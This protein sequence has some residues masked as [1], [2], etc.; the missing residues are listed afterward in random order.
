MNSKMKVPGVSID[1]EAWW[2][3]SFEAGNTLESI[4]EAGF[5][6]IDL[7]QTTGEGFLKFNKMRV[8][9]RCPTDYQKFI[10]KRNDPVADDTDPEEWFVECDDG[11]A[12]HTVATDLRNACSTG[13]PFCQS[14]QSQ[15][16][17]TKIRLGNEDRWISQSSPEFEYWRSGDF[18][19]ESMMDDPL[20][21]KLSFI[22][23][24]R[25]YSDVNEYKLTVRSRTPIWWQ[26][27]TYGPEN[28]TRLQSF[29][30][31]LARDE[32]VV[33][34]HVFSE[35]MPDGQLMSLIKP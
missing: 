18:R 6:L 32:R 5:S 3:I 16:V 35:T 8:L 13:V 28:F 14:L 24:E 17:S 9:H 25:G 34:T 29:L 33:D 11:T 2:V 31:E 12:L 4:S 7:L 10:E 26:K 22:P 23:K 27:E 1:D 20:S 21:L 15:S 19:D 30:S